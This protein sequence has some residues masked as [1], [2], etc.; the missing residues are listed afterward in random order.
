MSSGA[1]SAIRATQTSKTRK[2]R[3]QTQKVDAPQPIPPLMI[4]R[5]AFPHTQDPIETLVGSSFRFR[6][7]KGE[8]LEGVMLVK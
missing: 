7:T 3:P 4:G 5:R 8:A 6:K 1:Q 2:S